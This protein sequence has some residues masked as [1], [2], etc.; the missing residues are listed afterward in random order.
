MVAGQVDFSPLGHDLFLFERATG[1]NLLVTHAAG[2]PLSAGNGSATGSVFSDDG[3]HLVFVSRAGD[4]VAGQ[5]DG[6]DLGDFLMGADVFRYTLGD[7]STRLLSH[8]PAQAVHAGRFM[9]FTASTSA[10]ATRVLFV[11]DSDD[12]SASD[13]GNDQRDIYLWSEQGDEV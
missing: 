3:N 4:L 9:S 7:G 12:L 13:D 1:S 8:V 6:N 11:S 10:D 5:V 2:S